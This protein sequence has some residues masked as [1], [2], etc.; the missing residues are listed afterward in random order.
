MNHAYKKYQNVWV[1]GASYHAGLFWQNHEDWH[2]SLP[3]SLNFL[4]GQDM[5]YPFAPDLIPIN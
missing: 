3:F 1:V 2:L 5:C 4:I